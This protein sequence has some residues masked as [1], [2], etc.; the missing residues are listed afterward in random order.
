MRFAGNGLHVGG[1][2]TGRR[3]PGDEHTAQR[4]EERHRHRDAGGADARHRDV[5]DRPDRL[6]GRQEQRHVP[7]VRQPVVRGTADR[8]QPAP[9]G[10][11]HGAA[12]RRPDHD[13]HEPATVVRRV[14][15]QVGRDGQV[16]HG[17]RRPQGHVGVHQ[18]LLRGLRTAVHRG[19][20][21]GRTVPVVR[22]P[23]QAPAA[24][25]APGRLGLR[26]GGRRLGLD[27]MNERRRRTRYIPNLHN[28]II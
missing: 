16:L 6:V 9:V 26:R 19:P 15:R 10:R 11:R 28:I 7:A 21:R 14:G 8:G 18:R 27:L 17:N 2:R 4:T 22:E 12:E 20:R 23:D 25:R 5:A 13:R 3:S 1:G 24:L